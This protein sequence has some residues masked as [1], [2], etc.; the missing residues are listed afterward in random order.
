MLRFENAKASDRTIEDI[1]TVWNNRCLNER[2]VYIPACC[3]SVAEGILEG[4]D[5]SPTQASEN[6]PK[7]DERETS[8]VHCSRTL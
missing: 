8:T 2:F 1:F 3:S 4:S 7:D 5:P 6:S